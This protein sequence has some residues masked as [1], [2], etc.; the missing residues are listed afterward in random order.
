MSGLA[1]QATDRS[2]TLLLNSLSASTPTPAR[3]KDVVDAA[4]TML[5]PGQLGFVINLEAFASTS[6]SSQTRILA[7]QTLAATSQTT[8]DIRYAMLFKYLPYE[9]DPL[10]IPV[11]QK[12]LA[13]LSPNISQAAGVQN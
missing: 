1:A 10:V 11:L 8:P 3:Q 6:P 4:L 7:I 13:S 2:L 9:K 5:K 12:A